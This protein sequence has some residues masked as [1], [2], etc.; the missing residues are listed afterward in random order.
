MPRHNA[1]ESGDRVA[2]LSPPDLAPRGADEFFVLKKGVI[3]FN[4]NRPPTEKKTEGLYKSRDSCFV[5][6]VS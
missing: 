1:Q 6:R 4:V 5:F 2:L 3:T